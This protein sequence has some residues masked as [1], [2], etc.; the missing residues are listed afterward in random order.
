ME[1]PRAVQRRV[2]GNQLVPCRGSCIPFAGCQGWLA[3]RSLF[4]VLQIPLGAFKMLDVHRMGPEYRT[5]IS[6][7]HRW[8]LL[9][10]DLVPACRTSS[11]RQA[12]ALCED[13]NTTTGRTGKIRTCNQETLPAWGGYV[14]SSRSLSPRASGR[15]NLR[16]SSESKPTTFT[17]AA[18][19]SRRHAGHPA[20]STARVPSST[21]S[22]SNPSATASSAVQRTQ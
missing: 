14:S 18:S 9:R 21:M 5:R 22:V 2:R 4:I 19:S 11:P 15:L 10:Q 12:Y 1:S 13:S 3:G 6:R 16:T 7:R 8:P 20:G 17:P